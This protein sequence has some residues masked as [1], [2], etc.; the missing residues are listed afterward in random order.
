MGASCGARALALTRPQHDASL[1]SNQVEGRASTAKKI[2]GPFLK[3]VKA[4]IVA[5]RK[6]TREIVKREKW[7]RSRQSVRW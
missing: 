3:G 7:L 2:R 6:P 4:F 5:D 1:T